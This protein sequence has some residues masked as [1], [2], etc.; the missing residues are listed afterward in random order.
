MNREPRI[1][2]FDIETTPF[3]AYS[4]GPK[5]NVNLIEYIE[6]WHLLCFAYKWLGEDEIHVVGQD[7][8]KRDYRRNRRDDRRVAQ[9]LWKV[10][11]E[12]DIVIGHN[13]KKFDIKKANARFA[14]HGL[15]RP[16]PFAVV[17]TLTV[18]RRQFSFGSNK[19]NDLGGFLDLGH[20][21][22]HTGFDL[23]KGCM[24]GDPESWETMKAYN[25]QDVALL[26]SVY[27]KFRDEGWVTSH[28]NVAVLA[29]DHT[30]CPTC[31]ADG[32]QQQKRGFAATNAHKYQRF[33]CQEC[34]SYHRVRLAE[35][36]SRSRLA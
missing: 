3:V 6:D 33:Q 11:D 8:F 9:E 23:W 36:D 16:A 17:D 4:W 26:E 5:F 31:G 32:V 15:G 7:D 25:V 14:V 2:L 29:G 28:P 34:R 30:A 27:L 21:L 12:A 24:A 19:L 10:M 18:A 35:P 13:A 22:V 1:L 20:K